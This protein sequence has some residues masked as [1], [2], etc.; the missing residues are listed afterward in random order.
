MRA[1][2][3]TVAAGVLFGCAACGFKGP[4]YLP[5]HTGVVVTHPAGSTPATTT[6]APAQR[7]TSRTQGNGSG[8]P[9]P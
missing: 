5:R 1:R 2:T 4:L 9:P 6:P 7:K 3:L 8:T